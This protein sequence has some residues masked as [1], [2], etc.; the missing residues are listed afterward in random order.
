MWRLLYFMFWK[1]KHGKC[2]AL[3]NFLSDHRKERNIV[4]ELLD[5][6]AIKL[7]QQR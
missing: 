7:L 3:K 6:K 2:P 4:I 5:L 1:K